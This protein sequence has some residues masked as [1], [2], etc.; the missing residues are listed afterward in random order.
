MTNSMGRH[1]REGFKNVGRNGWMTF[2]SVSAVAIT[3]LILGVFLLLAFNV[4]HIAEQIKQQVEIQV[5][6]DP[7]ADREVAQEV[8]E[9]IDSVDVVASNQFVPREEGLESL[10]ERFG[11]RGYLLD[12]LEEENPLPH[13]FIVKTQEPEKTPEAAN[14]LEA[15]S[16]VEDVMYGEETVGKLFD[17]TNAVRKVGLFFIVGLA[18]TAMFLIANTI[19]LTIVARRKEIEIMKLVGATN[20]F[21]RWPFFIEGFLLGL[22]GS[23]VPVVLSYVAYKYLYD[24]VVQNFLFIDLLPLTPFIYMISGILIVI[25]IFI[26]VWGSLLSVRRF[27]KV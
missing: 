8:K 3:L 21:I 13:S 12:G 18:F 26:G 14:E 9:E 6:L 27:L 16:E 22:I 17:V 15:I 2:A 19:K 11:E 4:N 25:G 20:G 5:F 24:Y 1:I 7:D 23:I 10:K